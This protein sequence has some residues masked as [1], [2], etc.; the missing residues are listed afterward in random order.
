MGK[1][2]RF[3]LS[4]ALGGIRFRL[5]AASGLLI[6]LLHCITS[7]LPLTKWL[8]TWREK[9]FLT[10]HSAYTHWIGLDLATVLP[11]LLFT[12]LPL[13]AA[14]PAADSGWWDRDSGYINH[15]R[16]RCT[17]RQYSVSKAAAVFV[18]AFLAA[19]IPL[20]ADFLFTSA[21]LPCVLPE[22]AS[23]SVPLT[24]K[25]LFGAVFY[26]HPVLYIL[27]YTLFDGVFLAMW[28][29]LALSL[30]RWMRQRFQVLLTPFILYLLAYFADIW[31]GSAFP[32]PMALLLPFQPVDGVRL[33]M[34]CV[35]LAGLAAL[36]AVCWFAPGGR[37]DA[38]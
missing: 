18:S 36:L 32:S 1:V 3:E 5:C 11:V 24:D 19:F 8:D 25:D 7:V 4:R 38:I 10:P 23:G 2:F 16:L 26:H 30:S 21:V 33:W 6:A 28:T 27:G 14:L 9:P 22:P 20:M 12:V 17:D 34:P 15:I 37:D 31:S 35:F 13:F 29:T